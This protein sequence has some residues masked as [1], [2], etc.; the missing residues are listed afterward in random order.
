MVCEPRNGVIDNEKRSGHQI[1]TTD[2]HHHK[3][4]NDLI[5]NN[6]RITQ[7]YITNDIGI[8]KNVSASLLNN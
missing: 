5:K 6:Q 7:K 2:D 1:T 8:S 3:L 4:V